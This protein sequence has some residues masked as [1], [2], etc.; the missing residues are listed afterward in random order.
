M[1]GIR[2][3]SDQIILHFLPVTPS[4]MWW[5][6]LIFTIVTRHEHVGQLGRPDLVTYV[7]L[8]FTF[9]SCPT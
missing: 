3:P 4:E 9:A 5:L 6:A 1:A 8:L 7:E 2:T